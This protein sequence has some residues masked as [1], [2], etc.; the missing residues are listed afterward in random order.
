[1]K[2][3]I[4]A[5]GEGTRLRPLTETRPK[6]MLY[7]AGK[8]ILYHLLNEAKKAG[9]DEAIIVVRY[10]KEKI[11]E[12]LSKNNL[13]MKIKFIE[14][15]PGNGTGAALLCAQNEITDTFVTLAGDIVT[16]ASVIK[17]VMDAHKGGITL[18]L[19]KV[20]HPHL[21]GVV[22][23]SGD[24]ISLFEEKAKH[25]KSDLAN[26][27]VYCMEPTIFSELKSV[28][29]S[30]RGEYEL[31][32]LFIG[33]KGVVVD[34]YWK[35]IAY[36]W[37]L[38]DANEFLLSK[39][40]AK[41]G[42]IENST[43]EGK[44]IMEEGAKIINSYIEGCAYIGANTIVGPNAYLR[45]YNSIG[46]NCSVGGGTT[47]KNSILLDHVNAKHLAYIGDSVIGEDVNFGS[48][49]QIANY[50]F[51][52]DYINVMTERG[53]TNSGKKKLGVFVGDNTKFGV[54]SCTMPGKL[55]GSNCW[56]GSGV[57]VREN[58]EANSHI[59]VKQEVIVTKEKKE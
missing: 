21:Y 44:V 29:K 28:G 7:V 3:V 39:M 48:G 35:D 54:L 36:P 14:Q 56:I 47:I 58:L 34:G 13:G 9:I 31:V 42:H 5:A 45:G 38:F 43:I 16:E 23:L 2:C 15:G 55:I 26:L 20:L 4:L 1:M 19:K 12:Y 18:A 22:E 27:S 59:F 24:K 32:N 52:S 11:I 37:D 17:K 6:P 51:D 10:K 57:V 53:W 33:A 30:E 49:T 46:N 40:E 41:T 8:P 50:R 25:P